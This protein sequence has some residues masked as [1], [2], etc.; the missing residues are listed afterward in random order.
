[1]M[2]NGYGVYCLNLVHE[3][4]LHIWSYEKSLIH[5]KTEMKEPLYYTTQYWRWEKFQSQSGEWRPTMRL[6]RHTKLKGFNAWT[7]SLLESKKD[8][9][10]YICT[11]QSARTHAQIKILVGIYVWDYKTRKSHPR[12]RCVILFLIWLRSNSNLGNSIIPF[13]K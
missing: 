13:K 12:V 4:W 5:T 6:R 1:M 11:V 8:N 3:N 2:I 10:A 9:Y 7:W